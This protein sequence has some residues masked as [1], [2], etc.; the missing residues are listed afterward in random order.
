[1]RGWSCSIEPV[2]RDWRGRLR[3]ARQPL[4]IIDLVCLVAFYI[5]IFNI[6]RFAPEHQ[7][8]AVRLARLVLETS[9]YDIAHYVCCFSLK[10]A[11][12]MGLLVPREPYTFECCACCVF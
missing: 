8:M 10:C 2:Y 9:P 3:W 12:L 7:R 4:Q 1:M 11:V 5:D 6:E